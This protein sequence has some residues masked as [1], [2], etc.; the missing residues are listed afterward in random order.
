MDALLLA[1]STRPS[2]RGLAY[3]PGRGHIE[4]VSAGLEAVPGEIDEDGVRYGH[5]V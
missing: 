1:R 3:L 5:R 2:N 4:Q